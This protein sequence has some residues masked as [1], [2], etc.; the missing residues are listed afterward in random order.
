MKIVVSRERGCQTCVFPGVLGFSPGGFFFFRRFGVFP[1]WALLENLLL[2][3]SIAAEDP[4]SPTSVNSHVIEKVTG[5]YPIGGM[6][7]SGACSLARSITCKCIP[8]IRE[9]FAGRTSGCAS[10]LK[11][12]H[13]FESQHNRP[14]SGTGL[15]VAARMMSSFSSWK[16]STRHCDMIF[17]ICLVPRFTTAST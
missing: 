15:S 14:P 9:S 5:K 12:I 2:Q 13:S 10:C 1:A 17:P 7:T 16:P 11:Q 3:I 6:Y 4:V 8:V